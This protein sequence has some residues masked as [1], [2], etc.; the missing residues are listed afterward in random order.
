MQLLLTPKVTL[1]HLSQVFKL[2]VKKLKPINAI[3]NIKIGIK[4]KS[5]KRLPKRLNKN[6]NP[7]IGKIS[8]NIKEYVTKLFFIL[9]KGNIF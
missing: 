9:M 3:R 1:P 7:K 5:N 2:E 6:L 8:K 4:I